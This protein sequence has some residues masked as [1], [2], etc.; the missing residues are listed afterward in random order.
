MII[1]YN[2]PEPET[3]NPKPENFDKFLAK[4]AKLY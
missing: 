2:G 3:Q 1:R 4:K